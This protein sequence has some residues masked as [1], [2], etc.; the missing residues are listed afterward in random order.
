MHLATPKQARHRANTDQCNF[1]P[2]RTQKVSSF[3]RLQY[4]EKSL[5][6]KRSEACMRVCKWEK[7]GEIRVGDGEENMSYIIEFL[8]LI[9]CKPIRPYCM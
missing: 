2:T 1:A 9:N 8:I 5:Q 6:E 3:K 7:M 4:V